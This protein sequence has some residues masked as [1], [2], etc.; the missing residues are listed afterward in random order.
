[1]TQDPAAGYPYP[2]NARPDP[3][4][5]TPD[6]PMLDL[7]TRGTCFERPRVVPHGVWI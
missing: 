2:I 4:R 7:T 3:L 5:A 6:G 1:M